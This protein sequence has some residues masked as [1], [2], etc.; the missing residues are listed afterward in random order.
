MFCACRADQPCASL[1]KPLS[2][3]RLSSARK[4]AAIESSC[5]ARKHSP[6]KLSESAQSCL[7]EPPKYLQNQ[8]HLAARRQS[9]SISRLRKPSSRPCEDIADCAML[10]KT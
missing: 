8:R 7:S 4:P 10:E 2:P 3:R 6:P 9:D 5:V 1:A